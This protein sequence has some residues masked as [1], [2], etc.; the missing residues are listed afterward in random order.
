METIWSKD[1]IVEQENQEARNIIAAEEATCQEFP[2]SCRERE[3]VW[4][5]WF[6]LGENLI[7]INPID[8][9]NSIYKDDI[10]Y[11]LDI[12]V[13]EGEKEPEGYYKVAINKWN[14]CF[15]WRIYHTHSQKMV[16]MQFT[17]KDYLD[18]I[19]KC[20]LELYISCLNDIPIAY[21]KFDVELESVM[22][23]RR[24]LLVPGLTPSHYR[25]MTE[26][27]VP[28]EF[29]FIPDM[30][31]L[32]GYTIG[33]GNR[34]YHIVFTHWDSDMEQVRHQ[35]ESYI[36]SRE[37]EIILNFDTDETIIKVRHVSI[38]DEITKAGNGYGYKYKDYDLVEIIP[39]GFVK[40]PILKGYCEEKQAIGQ[41]YE[42]LLDI[43]RR[44]P[45]DGEED[46][47]DDTPSRE[48]AYN[49]YKSPILESYLK[50]I[51][52][53]QNTYMVR[54]TI[55]KHIVRICPDYNEYL[56]DEDD[57]AMGL[58]ELYDNERKPIQMQELDEWAQEIV[59]VVLASETSR[60][61]EKDWSDFNKRGIDLAHQLRERLSP[62]FD[63]W[64]EAPFEDKSDT[65]VRRILI[66]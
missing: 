21:K 65:I 2:I 49:R 58:D 16:Q 64:Y 63:L 41:L 39:N 62:D 47:Y 40:M 44:H 14:S 59:Q 37:A 11:L 66:Y 32:E 23:C 22:I 25:L 53:E 15:S 29:V 34:T 48:V 36:Y 61:Y 43:A 7:L 3:G 56:W 9:V 50:G 18:K 17:Y 57:A 54:Q 60:P 10:Y 26:D 28:E 42:G 51:K 45:A 27:V 19:Q 46:S 13:E 55:V 4:G 1:G 52:K 30:D 31:D 5:I 12:Y 33:I 24:Q 35:L 20:V 38:L 8:L 6:G